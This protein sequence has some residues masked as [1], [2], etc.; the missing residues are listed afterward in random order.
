MN[1]NQL[2][3]RRATVND[4]TLIASFGARTFEEAY[5]SQNKKEDIE[6]YLSSSFNEAHIRSQLLD[7]SSIFLL[8]YKGKRLVGY[9]MLYAGDAPDAVSGLR[10]IE[11]ARIYIDGIHIG[12]GFGSRLMEA[13]IQAATETDH[14]V[15]WLGVWKK[16]ERAIAFYRKCGFKKVGEK[17]FVVGRDVQH[18]F[19]MERRVNLAA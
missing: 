17:E 7:R 9:S 14:D 16:N 11:L 10:P 8:A 12:Q 13:C 1:A 3:I 18:D 6:E 15:I 2:S 4:T 19:I 5:G